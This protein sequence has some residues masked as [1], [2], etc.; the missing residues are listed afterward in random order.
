MKMS[1]GRVDVVCAVARKAA[2][3]AEAA[4]ERGLRTLARSREALV[5]AR[6][7]FEHSR[8]VLCARP[9]ELQAIE[10]ARAVLV[11]AA[12]RLNAAMEAAYAARAVDAQ[13]VDTREAV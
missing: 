6:F 7:A 4:V 1:T 2:R 12:A 11:R 9:D 10:A 8:A 3:Q 5:Q 13:G